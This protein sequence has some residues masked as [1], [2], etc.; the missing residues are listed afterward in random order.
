PVIDQNF[1]TTVDLVEINNITISAVDSIGRTRSITLLLDGDM[2]PEYYERLLGFDPQNPDSDSSLTQENE[3]GNGIPDGLEDFDNDGLAAYAEYKLGSDPF[4]KDTDGDGLEDAFE[5]LATGTSL[6]KADTDGNGINDSDEDTDRDGLTNLEEQTLGTNPLNPDTDGDTLSD[7]D[8]VKIHLTNPLRRDTDSD[9]LTDDV[10]IMLGSDPLVADSDGDGILDGDEDYTSVIRDEELGVKVAITG[11]GYLAKELRIYNVT[12]E[13][14][15]NISALVSHVIDFSLDKPFEKAEITLTYDA[16]KVSDPSNLSLFY[17]NETLGTFIQIESTVDAANHTVTGITSHF[18]TFAIFYVPN[19]NALFEAEMN[20]GRGGAD[21]VYVDVMFTMDSSGSMSWNDPYGYRKIA[22]KNFVGALI[23]GDRAGVVD[24]DSSAYLIRPLTD[25]FNAVNSSIDRIDSSGGTNIG[26]GVSVA[27][28]HL[29]NSGNSSHAWM[30]ILLTDGQGSYNNYYTQQAVANNITIYTIGL[31]S[32]VDSALLTGIATATGGKYYPVSSADQLPQVFRDISGEIEPTDSDNDGLSDALETGGFRDGFGNW[33]F[34]DPYDPD[35]DGDGLLDGEEA[36]TLV[37]FGGK[38]YFNIISKPTLADSDGDDLDDYEEVKRTSTIYVVNSPANAQNF[39]KAV[40]EGTDYSPYITA[41][42]PA[43][44]PLNPDTDFDTIPDGEEI[45]WGTDPGSRDTDGDGIDDNKERGYGEDPTIFDI[46]P[47][48]IRVDFLSVSKD[49]FSFTTKYDFWYTVSDY[50]GVKDVALLKNDI[51]RDRYSYSS[52]IT[53]VNEHTYFETDLETIL[54]AFRTA[55]V[56]INA[57][58]W[59]GNYETALVY[60]RPS[61]YGQMAARLGS[62]TIYGNEIAGNLGTLSGLSAAIAEIPELVIL[63]EDDPGGFLAGIRDLAGNIASDPSLFADLIASLPDAVKEKQLIENPYSKGSALHSSFANGWYSG[64]IGTQILS[65]FVG[66]G[67]LKAVTSSAKFTELT[68]SVLTKMDDLKLL[69][70]ASKSFT[71]T[72]RVGAFLVDDA[73]SLGLTAPADMLGKIKTA[74]KQGRV[75]KHLTNIGNSRIIS[76]KDYHNELVDILLRT[77]DDGA[78]F[79]SAMDDVALKDMFSLNVRGADSQLMG[80]FRINLV[81][82]N[83]RGVT[84]GEIEK[85]IGNMDKL[86]DVNG[87]DRVVRRVSAAG[88][89][90]NFKGAAFEVEYAASRKVDDIIEMGRSSEFSNTEL[91]KPGDIDL[92]MQEG[93]KKVGYEL[94]DRNFATWDRFNDDINDINKGFKDM[95]QNGKLDDYKIVFRERPPEDMIN[96]LD[97]KNIPWGHY[98]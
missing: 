5:L 16:Q 65:I 86:K 32:S 1:S 77:G 61:I 49:S 62:D 33:Y 53:T 88:D 73:A 11:K 15:T 2:L 27:N 25:D 3:A 96:W 89:P 55:R 63:I 97:S 72:E 87:I 90:G 79:V 78:N 17:F 45:I 28:N 70:R 23:P 20:M 41:I 52:R 30:M 22:A 7:S 6:L 47:P 58:D 50:G 8:E 85:F 14:F 37:E 46:T 71:V 31:G 91:T 76:L 60:H 34:S 84:S 13:I 68:G 67:E 80:K 38:K 83:T 57:D 92:I 26:A 54:D 10:E 81:K 29:I 24:F 40:Y 82:L 21:V 48:A 35:T 66:A 19:W 93:T 39:L 74:V 94:K 12:S 95:V 9:D 75:M 42:V 69:L 59:N 51:E 56:D 4:N 43:S 36:G 64:Y 98:V 44:N 18:S